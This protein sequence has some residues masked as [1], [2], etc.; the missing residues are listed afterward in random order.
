MIE[1]TMQSGGPIRRYRHGIFSRKRQSEMRCIGKFIS[2]EI[3]IEPLTIIRCRASTV[4]GSRGADRIES[5]V[6]VG[7]KWQTAVIHRR[8]SNEG[9][10][11]K[12]IPSVGV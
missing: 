4:I 6:A 9:K 12:R 5:R 8:V 3:L 10:A 2:T 7:R 11:R 1:V